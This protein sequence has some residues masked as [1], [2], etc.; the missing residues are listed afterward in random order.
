[1]NKKIFTLILAMVLVLGTVTT[2]FADSLTLNPILTPV[3]NEKIQSLI[4]AGLILGDSSG[5]RL[6]DNITR[7]EMVAMLIRL[8]NKDELAVSVKNM[9]SRFKDVELYNWANGY[10]NLATSL[11][12]I[13]GYPDGTFRPNSNISYEEVIALLVRTMGGLTPEEERNAVWSTT[14]ILKAVK[15]GILDDIFIVDYKN[16]AIRKNIFEMIYN[17]GFANKDK[18]IG[19]PIEV[20]VS[21]NSR[22]GNLDENTIKVKALK[23]QNTS[24]TGYKK[25]DEF[26]IDLSKI[27]WD[28]GKLDTEEVLG[29]ALLVY[30]DISKEPIKI[31]LSK[32][33]SFIEGKITDI[34][35][36][37]IEIEGKWHDVIT[38]KNSKNDKAL[39]SFIFNNKVVDYDGSKGFYKLINKGYDQYIRATVKDKDI[40]F[41]EAFDF[42]DIAPVI[43]KDKKDISYIDDKRDGEIRNLKL[44]EKDT[45]VLEYDGE[46]LSNAK[47]KDI[48][49]DS[50]IHWFEDDEGMTVIIFIAPKNS[51]VEGELRKVSY[52]GRNLSPVISIGREDIEAEIDSKN[53]NTVYSLF[54]EDD[55]RTLTDNYDE[56]LRDLYNRDVV[57]YKDIFGKL[58]RINSE[59]RVYES[60]GIILENS[61]N[62]IKILNQDGKSEDYNVNRNTQAYKLSNSKFINANLSEFEKD[63]LVRIMF[64]KYETFKIEKLTRASKDILDIDKDKLK[65]ADRD[66]SIN[67]KSTIFLLGNDVRNINL[68]E[69][70]NIVDKNNIKG[71]VIED[72][73]DKKLAKVV[74]ITEYRTKEE[75]NAEA[76]KNFKEKIDKLPNIESITLSD[77]EIV[78]ETRKAYESLTTE[79]KE[80]VLK[81]DL[82]KLIQLEEKLNNMGN[83]EN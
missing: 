45:I 44:K 25:N 75:I 38:D 83:I 39:S 30:F 42:I 34:K 11:G 77:K 79:Q 36:N 57:A 12:L 22:M 15:L 56:E 65:F 62:T 2:A 16:I 73:E 49:K 72:N 31:A 50:I 58:Q 80:L 67:N 6:G 41:A 66:Y 4:D 17:A 29:K 33:Y 60:M 43:E 3:A 9:P 68:E 26:T 47:I 76:V 20:I 19:N 7:A 5:F 35:S 21:E 32:G 54:T 40:I 53:F 23:D 48:K 61:L 24:Q 8:L 59:D 71:Y 10:I 13:K 18:T 37:K 69:F 78:E 28:K 55:Y 52:R 51:L 1:M 64:N 70:L 46:D 81:A 27:T 74:V 82:D 14:Y 63:N